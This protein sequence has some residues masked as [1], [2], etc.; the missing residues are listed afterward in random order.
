MRSIS[1][2]S[3]I[4]IITD[5]ILVGA[6]RQFQRISR[7][8]CFFE[9][10]SIDEEFNNQVSMQLSSSDIS[11]VK[12]VSYRNDVRVL[13]T[14]EAHL[15][16]H[17]EDLRADQIAQIFHQCAPY[18]TQHRGSVVV[19]HIPGNIL[20][21]KES[22]DAITDDISLLH[23][24]GVSIILVIGV[25]ELLDERV[26][27]SHGTISYHDGVRITDDVTLQYLKELSGFARYEIESKLARGYKGRPGNSGLNV[28]SGN[29]FYSAKPVGVRSGIDF[30]HTGEVR[31]IEADNIQT[32]LSQGDIVMLTSLG[33]SPSGEVFNVPSMALAS[34]CAAKIKASK[35]IFWTQGQHIIDTRSNKPLQSLRLSQA[36]ALLNTWNTGSTM[37]NELDRN[38][39]PADVAVAVVSDSDSDYVPSATSTVS[40]TTTSTTS[41][42]TAAATVSSSSTTSSTSSTTTP[43]PRPIPIPMYES[44][45]IIGELALEE[46]FI[47]VLSRCVYALQGGVNRA[48]LIPPTRGSLLKELYTHDGS[49]LLISRDVYESA[50][51]RDLEDI[52]RPLEKELLKELPDCY[53]LTR[54]ATTLA[55]G[56]LKKY[57]DTQGEIACLAVHPT[58]RRAGRGETMLAYLERRALLLG[59]TQLFILS[60][61][62]MQWFEERG[63][64]SSD[65]SLLPASRDYDPKRGAKVYI[66]QLGSQRDVDAEEVLWDVH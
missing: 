51:I 2:L 15:Q 46:S 4:I 5:V 45:G 37:D 41:T 26:L 38:D 49:G 39:T 42:T 21:N 8:R 30:I 29:F 31:R 33:Y 66:K 63:F 12:I 28:I 13:S 19:I 57:S 56:M 44:M 48:H 16:S 60:T 10:L 54:D 3:I 9:K 58:R 34:E 36:V 24:L 53:V 17:H 35:L 7:G 59:L 14:D 43:I 55:C 22:L 11:Y 1:I 18:I 23:L 61:R 25:K 47:Q 27:A 6:L 32:R 20:K 52:I 50:D 40:S 65:P 62:T 64:E